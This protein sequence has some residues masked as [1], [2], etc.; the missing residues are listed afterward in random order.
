MVHTPS[1]CYF[2]PSPKRKCSE[3]KVGSEVEIH[4]LVFFIKYGEVVAYRSCSSVRLRR[5]LEM[6]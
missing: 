5:Y 1:F 2:N 4:S 6:S 3:E